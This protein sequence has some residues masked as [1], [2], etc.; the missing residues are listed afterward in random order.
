[1]IYMVLSTSVLMALAICMAGNM[2]AWRLGVEFYDYPGAH[3]LLMPDG[4]RVS[5]TYIASRARII[6]AV[7]KEVLLCRATTR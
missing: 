3:I 2:A 7:A 4:V 6:P 1:M 5:G